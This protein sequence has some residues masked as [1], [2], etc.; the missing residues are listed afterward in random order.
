MPEAAR[1]DNVVPFPKKTQ[2]PVWDAC[3]EALGYEP[4]TRSE[5]ALWG[6]MT[7][8]LRE[9]GATHE[10]IVSVAQWYRRH[11]PRI[12]LTIT[13]LEKWYSH[14]LRMAEERE[15]KANPER[16][17]RNWIR[18]VGWQY[19]LDDARDEVL[20]LS[21]GDFRV[22]QEIEPLWHELNAKES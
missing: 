6:K 21:D 12:D 18:N 16:R 14:F 9:A 4:K 8:S 15:E 3:V 10:Q 11:W 13:A 19:P 17:A 2:N 7:T 5:K 22:W 1:D 20:K